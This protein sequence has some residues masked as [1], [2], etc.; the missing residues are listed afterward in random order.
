MAR[1]AAHS[2][3]IHKNPAQFQIQEQMLECIDRE[4]VAHDIIRK[5]RTYYIHDVV[6]VTLD[7]IQGSL[8]RSVPYHGA[9]SEIQRGNEGYVPLRPGHCVDKF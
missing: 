6:K 9:V 3:N 1:N 4:P 8:N 2:Q 7:V 5:G